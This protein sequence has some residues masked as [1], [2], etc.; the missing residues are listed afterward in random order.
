MMHAH[1]IPQRIEDFS[2]QIGCC[3][4]LTKLF[5]IRNMGWHKT[6]KRSIIPSASSIAPTPGELICGHGRVGKH[7]ITGGQDSLLTKLSLI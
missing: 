3:P 7:R 6:E 4:G 5:V 1:H 2:Q